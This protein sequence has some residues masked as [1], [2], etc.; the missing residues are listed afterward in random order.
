MLD[1][2]KEA[3]ADE[4][5]HT[6]TQLRGFQPGSYVR[7]EIKN[8]PYEFDKYFNNKFPIILGGLLPSE[9]QLGLLQV[10]IITF[11][12]YPNWQWVHNF[13]INSFF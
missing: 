6:Q 12:W 13:L 10:I 11:H 1:V 2:N 5:L 7:I 8:V 9:R 3:F 4:D